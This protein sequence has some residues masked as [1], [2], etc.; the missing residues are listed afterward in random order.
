MLARFDCPPP[1]INNVNTAHATHGQL[2][3]FKKD[4][5]G[6]TVI[7]KL[8]EDVLSRVASAGNGE[9]I[10]A[11]SSDTGVNTLIAKLRGMDQ[12]DLGTYKFAGH[13]DRFQYF[14]AVAC[15]LVFLGMLIGERTLSL[16][17]NK[18]MPWHA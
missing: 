12:T 6:Q 8:N 5:D 15:I 14:L 18:L 9:Y 3:G 10:H 13:E 2:I 11:T 17:W 16:K 7:T 4:K 1:P